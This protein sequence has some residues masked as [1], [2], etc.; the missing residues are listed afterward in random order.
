MNRYCV[1]MVR[2]LLALAISLPALAAPTVTGLVEKYR[3]L[4]L[5]DPK[6]VSN[7]DYSV[8]HARFAIASG[9]AAP[10]MAG[11]EQVGIYIQGAGTFI[12]ETVDKDEHPVVRYNAR[13]NGVQ[14]QAAGDKL[15]I[16]EPFKDLFLWGSPL[17]ELSGAAAA[18]PAGPFETHRELF[19]RQFNAPPAEHLFAIRA[20]DAPAA[21][22]VRAQVG[23]NK[24]PFVY[25]FDDAY[26]KTESLQR[27]YPLQAQTA[28]LKQYLMTS[29]ISQQAIGRNP[30]GETAAN[31]MLTHLDV[32]LTASD[33]DNATLVVVEKL[34]LKRPLNVLRFDLYSDYWVDADREPRQFNVRSIKDK[35]GT[36]LPFSHAGGELLVGLAAT[37]SANEAI[38]LRFEI[39]GNFLF[40]PGGDNYW[41]LGIEPWFPQPQLNEQ[42]YTYHGLVK[43]KQPFIPFSP[44]KT[45][46]RATEGEYNVHETSFDQPVTFVAIL[47]G[48]YHIEVE[49]KDGKTLNIASY[50]GKNPQAAKQIANLVFAAMEWYPT[51]L[52][53][54]PFTEMNI[55]EKNDLGYAQAPPATIFVT[56]E[57]FNPKHR[58][59]NQV[60]QGINLRLAHE[61][62]HQYW[63]H[64]VKMP[65]AE[66][67]W[68]TESFAEYSSALFMKAVGRKG[69]YDRSMLEWRAGAKES[70][71]FAAIPTA[72]RMS[73]P[74]DGYHRARM[75]VGLVYSKGAYLL[76]GLHRELGDEA[77]ATFLKSY[78]KSFRWKFGTTEDV[79]GLL[80]FMTKKDFA[81]YFEQ[82][83]YGTGLPDVKK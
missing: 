38:E 79:I 62:A 45:I 4:R 60:V 54:F 73:N 80:Q 63:G 58:D 65:S 72:N 46:R 25:T 31:F 81:P 56:R 35:K 47:A 32:D 6:Q 20:L 26:S 10:V 74:G 7:F 50:A 27:L 48:K 33:K 53:P 71:E 34:V 11:E 76:A 51:I 18:P 15:T 2:I 16:S 3:A 19:A 82:Y 29:L 64:V 39:D 83:F 59:A 41:E 13:N 30:R 75:R 66:E 57:A 44:G 70:T 68:L 22:V 8:G 77:F 37:A 36:E 78:Q 61:V 67:Q 49:E 55:I 52:G 23:G 14:V 1:A 42:S 43:V 5:G 69:D 12:Y 40:R 9:V 17:P 28:K 21:K 24:H